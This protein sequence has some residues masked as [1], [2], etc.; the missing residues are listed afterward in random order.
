MNRENNTLGTLEK[1][2]PWTGLN[3]R[4]C[5]VAGWISACGGELASSVP[6]FNGEP[7]SSVQL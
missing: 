6:G 1:I 2:T 3:G 5:P 7:A 4:G